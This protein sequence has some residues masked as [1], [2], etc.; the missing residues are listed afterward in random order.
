MKDLHLVEAISRGGSVRLGS[1]EL[2]S[3][4]EDLPEIGVAAETSG[5]VY[6]TNAPEP[7]VIDSTAEAKKGPGRPKKEAAAAKG[8]AKKAP[9]VATVNPAGADPVTENPPVVAVDENGAGSG[10]ESNS[11]DDNATNAPEPAVID[12]TPS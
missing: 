9:E 10:D 6:A 1:G 2:V 7:A 11:Q 8:S 4:V 3:R 12:S 5:K